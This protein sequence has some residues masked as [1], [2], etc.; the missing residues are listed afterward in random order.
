MKSRVELIE[1]IDAREALMLHAAEGAEFYALMARAGAMRE[2]AKGRQVNLCGIINAKSG[3]CPENCAFCAQSAH[4]RTEI[5]TYPLIGPARIIEHARS[6]A[7][8][9]VR[10]FSIVTSGKSLGKPAEIDSV[11]DTVARLR[12]EGRVLRCASLGVLPRV[13]LARLKEAGLTKYHHNL[14][15]ARSFFPRI[16]TTHD[17][18]EDIAVIREA[19]ELGLKVCSGGLF[20]LG[21]SR[22]QRIELAETLRDLEV[23]AI[24]IN[25]LNPIPGTPLAD[26]PVLPAVECLKIIALFRLM[27]PER[28]IYVCGGREASL[29]DLQ[30]WIFMAGANGLMVGNYLTTSGRNIDLDLAMIR[31]L[32][33]EPT[34]MEEP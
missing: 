14:E 19:R 8:K 24:P 25:F 23:D 20:G 34:P 10:E 22:A 29:R 26:R 28:D 12:E 32:G 33:L 3:R 15:V 17:Y 31:D 18:E 30:S 6:L 2:A 5:T 9:G 7:G 13:V 16:C 11:F 4:F 1:P 27:M 21:E